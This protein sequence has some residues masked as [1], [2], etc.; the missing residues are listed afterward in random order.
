MQESGRL[1][2]QVWSTGFDGLHATSRT[3]GAY[4]IGV[5]EPYDYTTTSDAP[6]A[7]IGAGLAGLSCAKVLAS[8]GRAVTVFEKARGPSGRCAT[9]EQR[10]E[11]G[12]RYD[13]GAQYYTVR[14]Q[15]FR[16]QHEHWLAHGVSA[17]WAAR[18]GVWE[19]SQ[20]QLA[21]KTDAQERYI[22]TPGMS[23]LGRHLADEVRA[24][25]GSVQ[26][27]AAVIA[28]EGRPQAWHVRLQD[29]SLH[30]P[31]RAVVCT[32][33]AAQAAALVGPHAIDLGQLAQSLIAHPCWALMLECAADLAPELDG[34]FVNEHA[35]SWLAR[36]ASKPARA[37]RNQWVV[38]AA[39]SW[40]TSHLE[41]EADA[42]AR[43]M[44]RLLQEWL[45]DQGRAAA[46]AALDRPAHAVAHRWRYSIPAQARAERYA[47]SSCGSLLLA[48]D[49]HGGPRIEGAWLSGAAAGSHCVSH[50]GGKP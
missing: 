50:L 34:V 37:A 45:I 3:V 40:S 47:V 42:A 26:Y 7:V 27:E 29:G 5:S 19:P 23:A 43:A 22:G 15:S 30:G 17:L 33:P 31:Y 35:L 32:A 39:P 14:S 48:G 24:Q 41:L 28:I 38:Q 44:L 4:W 21:V 36:E 18:I 49:A 13:H 20:R 46:A 1:V 2:S 9:R 16:A 25:G 12:A 11:P 6:V 8:H 10:A